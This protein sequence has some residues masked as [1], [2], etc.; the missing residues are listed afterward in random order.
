LSLEENKEIVRKS[1]EI[2]NTQ[3]LSSIENIVAPDYVDNTRQIHGLENLKQFL[4][5]IFKSFPD[6]HLTI[7]DIIAEGDKVWI[8]VTITGTHIGEFRGLAPTGKKFTERQVWIY[9]IVKGKI[10]EGWDVDDNLDFYKQLGVIEY[11]EKGKKLFP[12]EAK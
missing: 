5:M 8:R 2:I 11:T 9:R 4:S 3:D 7:E 12:E 10:L 1:I 6:W